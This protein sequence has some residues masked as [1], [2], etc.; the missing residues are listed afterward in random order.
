MIQSKAARGLKVDPPVGGVG[1]KTEL[2]QHIFF[3]C[4][5]FDEDFFAL[6]STKFF[7]KILLTSFFSTETF[8]HIL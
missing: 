3:Y 8:F 1:G 4:S 5:D 7:K 6:V 2:L